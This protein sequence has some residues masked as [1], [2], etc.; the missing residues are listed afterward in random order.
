MRYFIAV[1]WFIFL[2]SCN[3]IVEYDYDLQGHRGCRGLLPENSI[4]AMLK[5]LELGVTTLE[6]DVVVTAD[7]VVILSHEP[8]LSSDICFD[9]D[10]NPIHPEEE[11]N[12]NLYRMK[13]LDILQYDCG[14][15][16]HPRFPE[17]KHFAI[18]KPK[19]RDVISNSEAFSRYKGRR[20][21]NYSIEIKSVEGGDEAFH[22]T[23]AK[24]VEAVLEVA[25]DFNLKDRLVI[26]S[27]DLRVLEYL[28]SKYPE[29]RTAYLVE[30]SKGLTQDLKRLS[31][32]PTIYS[33]YYPVVEQATINECHSMGIQV[34][35]WTVNDEQIAKHLLSLGVDGIIT[36]YPD[37]IH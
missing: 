2:S 11:S 4:P 7:S 17:Q 12:F 23:P 14:S 27:F 30:D 8:F 32:R 33:P 3:T 22:P 18:H 15:A 21:P 36:D 25:V 1:L 37:R 24:F 10:G 5:A 29:V 31:F 19:L 6:M 9:I 28:H 13:Y 20:L 26:Q 16:V 35:P 34:I